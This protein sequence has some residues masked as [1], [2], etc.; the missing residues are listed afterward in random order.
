M[1]I[2][3]HLPFPKIQ[4]S[5]QISHKD[6][7]L[8]IG[9]CF[10]T[11]LAT[12]LVRDKFSTLTNPS[13]TLFDPLSLA[14]AL[15]FYRKLPFLDPNSLFHYQDCYYSWDH[16]SSLGNH[17]LAQTLKNIKQAHQSAHHFLLTAD[18]II[19][20]LGTAFYYCLI[21]NNSP[22]Y[23]ARPIA[24]CH[25]YPAN[26]F[27]RH[28]LEAPN[29]AQVLDLE[30]SKWLKLNPKLR[31]ILSISPV[32]HGKNANNGLVDN[33]QSKAQLILACKLLCE[34]NPE[35]Y[36]YFPAY[37][38]LLDCLR[39]YRFYD[40]D[41]IHPNYLATQIITDY[42]ATNFFSTET[43]QICEHCRTIERAQKHIP[44]HPNSQAHFN[45]LQHQ[46][47]KIQELA[48]RYPYLNLHPELEYFQQAILT[49]P[50]YSA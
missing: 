40:I 1:S 27:S 13:G 34:Q 44:I 31:I 39:D 46:F 18:Y 7:I 37:E 6:R 21:D 11:H 20:T 49:H 29:I 43:Q 10:T 50:C 38:I 14:K 33:S 19:L 4:A 48:S 16:H 47:T 32:R 23:L 22:Y 36:Y 15:N 25:K 2:N 9:S 3:L 35:L 28:L 45:F 12:S 17:D 42:F 41:L 5:F 30:I 24:N 26:N 8:L